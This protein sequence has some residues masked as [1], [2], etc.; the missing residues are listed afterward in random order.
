[1]LLD[2]L[3]QL[4]FNAQNNT[5]FSGDYSAL[6][7]TYEGASY[8]AFEDL[9]A[10]EKYEWD[11]PDTKAY[12]SILRFNPKTDIHLPRKEDIFWLEGVLPALN[13]FFDKYFDA[14]EFFLNF[15]EKEQEYRAEV[16]T[17]GGKESVYIKLPVKVY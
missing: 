17:L 1:M 8:L 15:G 11:I 12:P 10:I 3:R 6:S 5:M 7:F 14:D 9:D 16:Q 13:E 2:D 4:I